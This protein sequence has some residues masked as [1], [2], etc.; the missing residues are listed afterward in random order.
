MNFDLNSLIREN[1][2]RLKPY[3]SA[4]NEFTGKAR[5]YLDANENSYGSP[6][7]KWYN[8]YP[9]PMQWELKKKISVIKNIAPEKS[10]V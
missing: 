10:C 5:I 3:S 9:D 2:K 4:R 6:L 1:V 7:P 8:R